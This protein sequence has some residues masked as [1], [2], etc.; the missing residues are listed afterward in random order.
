MSD[1]HM[2]KIDTI[3]N[4]YYAQRERYTRLYKVWTNSVSGVLCL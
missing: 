4:S 3:K 1:T 2:N